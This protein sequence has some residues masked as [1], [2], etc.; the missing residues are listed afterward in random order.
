[1]ECKNPDDPLDA[2]NLVFNGALVVDGGSIAV[3]IRTGKHHAPLASPIS[4]EPTTHLARSLTAHSPYTA[5]ISNAPPQTA[6]STAG[7]ATLIG[8][9]MTLSR[10]AT[11]S[12]STLKADLE[13]FVKFLTVFALI[14]GIAVFAVGCAR[15]L[16][17]IEVFVSGFVI[18]MVGNIPQGLPSTVTVCLTIIAQR[19]GSQNVFL[20]KLDI[21]ETL[22]SCT[23]ICTDKT[24]TLT[25]NIMSVAHLWTATEK[26]ATATTAMQPDAA[27]MTA[28]IFAWLAADQGSVA[29][30]GEDRGS[31]SSFVV[32]LAAML[33]STPSEA[34]ARS[35]VEITGKDRSSLCSAL[36]SVQTLWLLRIAC[37]NS[38][39]ILEIKE[40]SSKSA[41]SAKLEQQGED[42]SVVVPNGDASELGI[43]R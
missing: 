24:G 8:Q 15:G 27:P 25:M 17:P 43:Y 37:L 9:M 38:R 42:S 5:H 18:I 23:C 14:Q 36:W 3:V 7:D 21:L 11:V 30:S 28:P 6:H 34:R 12:K 33:K 13:F 32:P 41:K 16:P 39:V 2:K 40:G 31:R 22:G 19:M 26:A 20:K 1:V 35:E 10:G 4:Y 29:S